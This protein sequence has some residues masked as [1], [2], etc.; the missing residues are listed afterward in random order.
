MKIA[1][2]HRL[3][4]AA[5]LTLAPGYA[6]VSAQQAAAT[7]MITNGDVNRDGVFD[8][9]DIMR[10]ERTVALGMGAD[11]EEL[12]A[13]DVDGNGRLDQFDLLVLNE[14]LSRVNDG[15]SMFDAVKGSIEDDLSRTSDNVETYLDLARFYSK[16]Q[17][18]Q[19]SRDV[20]E[21]I[22]EALETDHPLY[23]QVSG[24]LNAA[25]RAQM[26][27]IEE[28][29]D[30]L[31]QDAYQ[32]AGD[33]AGKTS[34]RRAVVQLKGK[35]SKLLNNQQFSA[36]YNSKRV[37]SQLGDVMDNMLRTVN[38][39]QM[40][41]ASAL[42]NFNTEVR[43]V[44]ENPENLVKQ[45][46]S[47]QRS[48]LKDIIDTSTGEM[49]QEAVRLRQ[50]YARSPSQG[51]GLGNRSGMGEAV[52]NR[53]DNLQASDLRGQ[54]LQAQGRASANSPLLEPD[55]ISIVSPQYKLS[56][57]ASNILGAKNAALEIS[58]PNTKFSNPR[59]TEPDHDATFFY[60]PSMGTLKGERRGNALE[61]DGVGTYY[62]RI[63]ALNSKGE[64]I[65][66]FSDATSL[67]VVYN[68]LDIAANKPIIEPSAV[69]P[70]KPE[71]D[72]RWDVSN[73][74]GARDAAV[75]ITKPGYSFANPGGRAR[76]R[77]N[78]FFFNPSLGRT[79]GTFN[80][81]IDGLN[82]PGTYQFRVIAISPNDDF[83]GMWSE[84]E[85]LIVAETGDISQP[86]GVDADQQPRKPTEIP[87]SPQLESSADGLSVNW[88]VGEIANASGVSFELARLVGGDAANASEVEE[89]I[90]SQVLENTRGKF[91][92]EG[93]LMDQSGR[94]QA[95][96]AAVD[97]AGNMLSAWS[98]PSYISMQRPGKA[99]SSTGPATAQQSVQTDAPSDSAQ[100]QEQ[101][102]EAPPTGKNM[103][104][105]QN[106]T[107]L[108][109]ENNPS[110]PEI[111]SLQKGEKLIHVDSDGLWRHVYYP[112]GGK[113]GW[114]LSFN[115]SQPG[116]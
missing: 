49:R 89:V 100:Q 82:G 45:L 108:Y 5:C 84:P 76:D 39:D 90:V 9:F 61:L 68:N 1:V 56:W 12:S 70:E 43:G 23:N 22:L 97:S 73:I 32:A 33:L 6:Q 38:Q 81:S 87:P 109:E 37:K 111:A 55:T 60:T 103:E 110:S 104:V 106:N 4:T 48:Q 51:G 116:Q 101:A 54:N 86:A 26:R 63:A 11:E 15:I 64:L 52:L 78:T 13:A 88:D 62:Y 80:S 42:D 95:R 112:L 7:D 44:L 17:M 29:E 96:L 30:F 21:S 114:V 66:R 31:N 69:S 14:A 92:V 107:P 83:M 74:E 58:K 10:L 77:A 105:N 2:L 94:Y 8:I 113:Y 20:L 59:G 25:K 34:L 46:D 27:E 71:Y 115:V 3:I 91:E 24:Q 93:N 57:D 85:T 19:R 16:E 28:A 40:I 41:D 65:S 53:G 79:S 35:L 98:K 99:S 67:V 36:H 75:E 102:P 50:D 72:F 18:H 47:Q